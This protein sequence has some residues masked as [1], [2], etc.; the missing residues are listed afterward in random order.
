M[1]DLLEVARNHGA[2]AFHPVGTCRMGDDCEAVGY[3]Q[4][5]VYG[6]AGLRMVNA[7]VMIAEKAADLV[8]ADTSSA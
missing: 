7:S 8:L 6:I 4:L 3:P 2:T 1:R 5:R